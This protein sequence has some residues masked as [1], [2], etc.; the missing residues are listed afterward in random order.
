[1]LMLLLPVPPELSQTL[2]PAEEKQPGIHGAEIPNMITPS[3]ARKT[4]SVAHNNS[5]KRR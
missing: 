4:S 1:M 5:R 3:L 2:K